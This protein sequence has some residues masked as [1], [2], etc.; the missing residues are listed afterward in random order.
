MFPDDSR[1]E[2]RFSDADYRRALGPLPSA[3]APAAEGDVSGDCEI[4]FSP[5]PLLDTRHRAD[6]PAIVPD[7]VPG[8]TN[9]LGRTKNRAQHGPLPLQ[10]VP[11]AGEGCGG[12]QTGMGKSRATIRFRR[13]AR[14]SVLTIATS[15]RFIRPSRYYSRPDS[16]RT[17]R[18]QTPRS[19][20]PANAV[21][22]RAGS[23]RFLLVREGGRRLHELPLGCRGAPRRDFGLGRP[24][25]RVLYYVGF[26]RIV[27]FGAVAA[28]RSHRSRAPA[29][30]QTRFAW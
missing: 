19:L 15:R 13:I 28:R 26:R 8:W 17:D 24:A 11:V 23:D 30:G 7:D 16:R 27:T 5:A 14:C 9:E 22:S 25:G 3:V 12:F 1:S 29:A 20:S 21:S 18:G 10:R 2:K 4:R 6:F